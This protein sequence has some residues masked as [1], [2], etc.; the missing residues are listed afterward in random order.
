MD[1]VLDD[2][3][4]AGFEWLW[5][6]DADT[7]CFALPAPAPFSAPP[8]P[9]WLVGDLMG[10]LLEEAEADERVEV[11]PPL[12]DFEGERLCQFL[13]CSSS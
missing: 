9:L 6:G 8:P 3:A 7:S 2:A 1:A 5:R 10:E 13:L 11:V 4:A 12:D